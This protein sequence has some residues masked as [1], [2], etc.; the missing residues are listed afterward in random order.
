MPN[1]EKRIES[2]V[3]LSKFLNYLM[4]NEWEEL[5][6]NCSKENPWFT[7]D[8]IKRSLHGIMYMIEEEKCLNYDLECPMCRGEFIC[9]ESIMNKKKPPRG[10][11]LFYQLIPETPA[12]FTGMNIFSQYPV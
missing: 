3:A 10:K 2:I 9:K 4:E 1:L 6:F 8:S 5:F 7:E 11:Q 12:F